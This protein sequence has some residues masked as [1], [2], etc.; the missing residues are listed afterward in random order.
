MHFSLLSD[1]VWA[2]SFVSTA[3][4]LVVMLVRDRWRPFPVLTLWMAFMAT[5]TIVLVFL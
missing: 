4:L 5:R 2:A 3:T 1:A